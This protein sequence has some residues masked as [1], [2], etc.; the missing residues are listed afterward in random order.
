MTMNYNMEGEL[1]GWDH[2]REERCGVSA[3]WTWEK[4]NGCCCSFLYLNESKCYC[5]C[6]GL[7]LSGPQNKRSEFGSSDRDAMSHR[8]HLVANNT[9]TVQSGMNENFSGTYILGE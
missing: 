3:F 1:R 5:L 9:N 6:L 7:W 2:P 4:C 8:H